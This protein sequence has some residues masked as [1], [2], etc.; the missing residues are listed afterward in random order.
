MNL[1]QRAALISALVLHTAA[2]VG[3]SG[4]PVDGAPPQHAPAP[5]PRAPIATTP[6][7]AAPIVLVSAVA[8]PM[9]K[10]SPFS[11]AL[12]ADTDSFAVFQIPG[13]TTIDVDP[14]ASEPKRFVV[15]DARIRE[16]PELSRGRQSNV[17]FFGT[18]VDVTW[19]LTMSLEGTW[20]D[21]AVLHASA[22]SRDI[23]S[24][25]F[26]W[27]GDRWAQIAAPKRK[28][29]P[30]S[31]E[32]EIGSQRDSV[33]LATAWQGGT[34][35]LQ[36]WA[37]PPVLRVEGI[38]RAKPPRW[39]DVVMPVA[40]VA[41]EDGAVFLAGG[42]RLVFEDEARAD[43]ALVVEIVAPGDVD[44]K[45]AELPASARA[46]RGVSK[47]QY[48]FV[49]PSIALA[50]MAIVAVSAREAYVAANLPSRTG[51]PK[52][53]SE[54]YLA[55]WDGAAFTQLGVPGEPLE[56]FTTEETGA[57]LW[58]G[59]AGLLLRRGGFIYWKTTTGVFRV[60]VGGN[61]AIERLSPPGKKVGFVSFD[62][63]GRLFASLDG[64]ICR[65]EDDGTFTELVLPEIAIPP[66][67]EGPPR[68]VQLAWRTKD[69]LL[70]FVV[71]YGKSGSD[72]KLTILRTKPSGSGPVAAGA[73]TAPR[74]A[75]VTPATPSCSQP[76][77]VLYHVSRVAP[78]DYDFPA[79][80]E[81]LK[82]RTELAGIRF[83]E[84]LD[85]GRRYLVGFAPT[86]AL[87]KRLAE[88]ITEKIPTARPQVLCGKPAQEVRQ[89]RWDLVTGNPKK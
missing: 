15:E 36:D 86:F 57:A 44:G 1:R 3:C 45:T 13:L 76:F 6:A 89:V 70:A 43:D 46:W 10:E 27:K 78:P 87:G 5:A 63:A 64:A 75:F 2:S 17:T 49:P 37:T 24:R 21:A 61:G 69:D 66:G 71:S 7:D 80:R 38:A 29:P 50:E 84:T 42:K 30:L 77:V 26:R 83:A 23:T 34:L 62:P 25:D 8:P 79:T 74:S 19:F 14:M 31:P 18:K 16:A 33:L 12:V 54:S 59:D 67:A 73:S 32:Y 4:A 60:A 55:R 9:K 40:L 47:A 48:M 39:R 68:P 28:G 41:S 56:S 85:L 52:A 81:A 72:G 88:V 51:D 11:I 20:P 35:W 65:R 53:N 82:G 58:R 22:M